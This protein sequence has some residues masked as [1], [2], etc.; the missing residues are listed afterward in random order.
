MKPIRYETW[1][2]GHNMISNGTATLSKLLEMVNIEVPGL[3]FLLDLAT[4]L[5]GW[6]LGKLWDALPH[7]NEPRPRVFKWLDIHKP[8]EHK[9]VPFRPPVV[10]N[11]TDWAELKQTIADIKNPVTAPMLPLSP[12]ELEITPMAMAVPNTKTVIRALIFPPKEV[13]KSRLPG[14]MVE[15]KIGYGTN[16]TFGRIGF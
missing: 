14:R 10:E 11:A 1:I 5:L 13:A 16:A 7:E 3:G 2:K 12:E 6:G 15:P 9:T 4:G 8:G